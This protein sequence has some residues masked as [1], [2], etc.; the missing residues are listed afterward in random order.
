[1]LQLCLAQPLDVEGVREAKGIELGVGAHQTSKVL[2][3]GQEGHGFAAAGMACHCAAP[4][5]ES[6]AAAK[7]AACLLR[8]G[9]G[10]DHGV[11][12][13][14]LLLRQHSHG[15]DSGEGQHGQAPVA[16]L[17]ELHIIL[18]LGIGWVK[19][20][21][22]KVTWLAIRFALLHVDDRQ[23]SEEFQVAQPDQDLRHAAEL[24]HGV[25]RLDGGDLKGVAR[26][27]QTQIRRDPAH[28]GQHRHAAVL[29]L[30]FAEPADVDGQREAHGVEALL[31]TW[32]TLQC[33]R[34]RQK[35]HG[36][37][38]LV[39]LLCLSGHIGPAL[40]LCPRQGAP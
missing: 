39:S 40:L 13:R 21:Q 34:H 25:M 22:A 10:V 27:P 11:E 23:E 32:D 2:R 1:M 15:G 12:E 26:D 38:H 4:A 20:S 30:R 36:S 5:S 18:A 33:G 3:F 16:Q 14:P 31:F 9:N 37:T 7:G 28:G 29:Q 24:H 19:A 35:W 8:S 6:S 17:L